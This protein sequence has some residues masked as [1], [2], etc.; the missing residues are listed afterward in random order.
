MH[1]HPGVL[2]MPCPLHTPT[3]IN[4]PVS[5]KICQSRLLPPMLDYP[6]MCTQHTCVHVSSVTISCL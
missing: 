6:M 2:C 4:M 3:H 1:F 5:S